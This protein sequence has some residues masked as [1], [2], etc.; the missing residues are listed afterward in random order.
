MWPAFQMLPEWSSHLADGMDRL[1]NQSKSDRPTYCHQHGQSE[2]NSVVIWEGEVK[3]L[4]QDK[5][6]EESY[7]DAEDLAYELSET[8]QPCT[9]PNRDGFG[10]NV[11]VRQARDAHGGASCE[12]QGVKTDE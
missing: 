8:E 11:V 1:F 5:A 7:S 2:Q 4:T 6:D 12:E 3:S 9:L 10:Y